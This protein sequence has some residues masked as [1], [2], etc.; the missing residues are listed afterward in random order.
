MEAAHPPTFLEQ[1]LYL[2]STIYLIL[3]GALLTSIMLLAGHNTKLVHVMVALLAVTEPLVWGLMLWVMGRGD[4]M[5][6][7]QACF[8]RGEWTADMKVMFVGS[9]VTGTIKV[10]YLLGLFGKDRIPDGDRKVKGS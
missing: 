2:Q 10:A 7:I 4:I 5:E 1:F 6:G 8:V 9:G 3:S